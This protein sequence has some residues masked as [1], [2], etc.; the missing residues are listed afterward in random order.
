MCFGQ[1]T[2][3]FDKGR[4]IKK[5]TDDVKDLFYNSGCT[6]GP[7]VNGKLYTDYYPGL[8]GH[9]YMF[10]KVWEKGLVYFRDDVQEELLINYDIVGDKLLFNKFYSGGTYIIELNINDIE[11]FTISGHKF[12]KLT[13]SEGSQ[14]TN[15]YYEVLYDGKVKLLLKWEKYISKASDSN[16]DISYLQKTFYIK[17]NTKLVKINKRKSI[18]SS[19]SDQARNIENY[20]KQNKFYVRTAEPE[21]F[22]E[23]MIYYDSL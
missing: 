3:N 19:L 6:F 1:Q 16:K 12:I 9:Q 14:E 18:I 22:I 2:G 7:L 13:I 15:A 20:I 4:N 21:D 17:N 23:L 5:M 10:L 11:G 8:K